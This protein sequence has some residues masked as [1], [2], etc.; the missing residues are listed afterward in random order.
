MMVRH[1]ESDARLLAGWMNEETEVQN[2]LAVMFEQLER[3]LVAARS[4]DVEA[5]LRGQESLIE[6]LEAAA[7]RREKVLGRMLQGA[8]PTRENISMLIERAPFGMRAELEAARRRLR[9][10]VR[11]VRRRTLRVQVLARH[12]IQLNRELVRG[13]FSVVGGPTVYSEQGEVSAGAD[14]ILDRSI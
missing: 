2:E 6:R 5:F 9:T 8:P 1:S 13:L 3:H 4:A 14:L 12:A 11:D 7:H 10:V